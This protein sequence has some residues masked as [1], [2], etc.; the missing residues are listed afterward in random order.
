MPVDRVHEDDLVIAFRDIAPRAP[1]HILLIPRR[2]HR[3]GRRPTE[4][5]GAAARPAVRGRGRARPRRGDRRRR[6]P[7]R[8]ERRPLGRPDRRPPAPPPDGRTAVRLAARMRPAARGSL[9]SSWRVAARGRR[10]GCVRRPTA[11]AP[12]SRR[13]SVGPAPTVSPPSARRAAAIVGRARRAAAPARA[14]RRRPYRPAER[15]LLAAAP[16]A[17]YQVDPAG[18]PDAR[19]HRRLRVP[20]HGARRRGRRRAAALPR[21]RPGP[22]PVPDRTRCTSSARS[23]RRSSSTL[24]AGERR[25]DPRRARHPGGAR[26]ARDRVPVPRLSV[27]SAVSRLAHRQRRVDR[28]AQARTGSRLTL[29][30]WVRGKSSSG[31]SRQPAIRWFGPRVALA[32]LTAASIGPG[33]PAAVR[34]SPPSARR[35][36]R[37]RLAPGRPPRSARAAS[38]RRPSRGCRRPAARSRCPRDTR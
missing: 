21:H 31:Q 27:S 10:R 30:V 28:A 20:R 37:R 9:A 1:T 8:D 4:A 25:P 38:R 7:A 19:L 29:S 23:G 12:P 17:V 34:R 5:D 18:R 22:G 33:A 15:P 2:A 32:A 6:L 26:D 16:R 13:R 14:T 3:L 35:L 11:P 24:V 36:R